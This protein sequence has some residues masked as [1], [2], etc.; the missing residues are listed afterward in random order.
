MN[1]NETNGKEKPSPRLMKI[2][3]VSMAN[4][5]VQQAAFTASKAAESRMK[6]ATGEWKMFLAP[7][8]TWKL[9]FSVYT[10]Q[11]IEI[12]SWSKLE[13]RHDYDAT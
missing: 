4:F 13:G 3:F 1:R 5:H 9:F 2:I 10:S 6:S 11:Q 8:Q 12:E 7:I